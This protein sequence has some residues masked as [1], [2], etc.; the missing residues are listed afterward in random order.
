MFWGMLEIGVAMVAACLP[1]LRPLFQD[2]SSEGFFDSIRSVWTLRSTR[3]SI[4]SFGSGR[5]KSADSSDSES[6]V[7]RAA[8]VTKIEPNTLVSID[9]EA[10]GMGK[11]YAS[12]FTEVEDHQ[13]WTATEISQ[14]FDG[15]PTGPSL[16]P[17][18]SPVS[19]SPVSSG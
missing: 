5:K 3:A 7:P 9:V 8:S 15:T 10:F 14:C 13:I 1:F 4:G 12:R 18:Y 6:A 11:C 19:Y 2:W 16:S 17:I